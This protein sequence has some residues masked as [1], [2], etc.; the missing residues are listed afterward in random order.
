MDCDEKHINI[1]LHREDTPLLHSVAK[2]MVFMKTTMR[3][4]QILT[5]SRTNMDTLCN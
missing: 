2:K 3:I 1:Y 5:H 4:C